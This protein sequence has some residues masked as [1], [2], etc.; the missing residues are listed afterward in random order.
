MTR[1]LDWIGY[2]LLHWL[3]ITVSGNTHTAFG[4][5]CLDR[6]GSHAYRGRWANGEVREPENDR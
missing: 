6:A 2:Q 5:W 3:P 1:A 4:R